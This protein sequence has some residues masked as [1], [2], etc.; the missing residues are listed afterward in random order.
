MRPLLELPQVEFYSLQK[1]DPA[2]EAQGSKVHDF[3]D[4]IADFAE[5]A[6]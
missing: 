1:G 3:M 5:T 2:R 4:E 6:A